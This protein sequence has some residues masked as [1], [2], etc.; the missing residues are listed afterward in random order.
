MKNF[1]PLKAARSFC[2]LTLSCLAQQLKIDANALH[3]I[4]SRS[5]DEIMASAPM[6]T[7]YG[8]LI[9]FYYSLNV[10]VSPTGINAIGGIFK[11]EPQP[12]RENLC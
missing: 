4:E 2:G 8:R 10:I 1:K 7:L 6:R 9:A 3:R 5:I 12:S 11:P